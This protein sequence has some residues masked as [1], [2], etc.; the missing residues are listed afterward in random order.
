MDYVFRNPRPRLVVESTGGKKL[1]HCY[2]ASYFRVTSTFKLDSEDL[3]NLFYTGA[4]GY[5]QG[6]SLVS[7]SSGSDTVPCLGIDGDTVIE[8]PVNPYS[9]T[10]ARYQPIQVPFFVYNTETRCDSGD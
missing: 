2:S 3:K 1:G 8:N 7:E 9:K 6:F 4:L 10:G 5:G